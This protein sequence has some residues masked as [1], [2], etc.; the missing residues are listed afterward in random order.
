M[1][2]ICR[3]EECHHGMALPLIVGVVCGCTNA[4]W[5]AEIPVFLAEPANANAQ[6]GHDFRKI[7]S[8]TVTLS[9]SRRST[10]SRMP[11]E[12]RRVGK[13]FI[14]VP[15]LPRFTSVGLDR[16]LWEAQADGTTSLV[17]RH[18]RGMDSADRAGFGRL[19]GFRRCS[20]FHS[21][22]WKRRRSVGP[23]ALSRCSRRLSSHFCQ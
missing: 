17:H 18:D 22:E 10:G 12:T 20:I 1:T 19:K 7:R 4:R 11:N 2:P 6:T 3:P 21:P 15:S 16:A 13:P 5:F 14:P 23:V 9:G 8:L